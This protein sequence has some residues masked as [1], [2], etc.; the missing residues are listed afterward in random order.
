MKEYENEIVLE[1][2]DFDIVGGEIHAHFIPYV[3]VREGEKWIKH[4]RCNHARFH[5][6]SYFPA[7]CSE[8][9]C[10]IN[11]PMEKK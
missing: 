1:E 2:D 8:R 3:L 6:I 10:I 9:D 4:V 7:C 5:V 11:K